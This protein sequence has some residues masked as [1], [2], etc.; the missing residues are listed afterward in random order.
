MVKDHDFYSRIGSKG[1][2]K[3]ALRGSEFYSSIG[4]KGGNA[5]KK[6]KGFKFYSK[7]GKM[8]PKRLQ[9]P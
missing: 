3:T 7:I 2:Q 1:G 5:V 6:M 8:K 4:T 9:T